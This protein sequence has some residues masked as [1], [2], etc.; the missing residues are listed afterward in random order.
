MDLGDRFVSE[1]RFENAVDRAGQA[2]GN[3]ALINQ[4]N[5]MM[6]GVTSMVVTTRILR[7]V[8]RL[9]AGKKV[10][11]GDLIRL[12]RS[13]ISEEQARKIAAQAEHGERNGDI[14]LANIE[15][16]TDSEAKTAMRDA[17]LT[18]VDNT[19]ITPGAADSPLW[20]RLS[21]SS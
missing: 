9:A 5:T 19:I 16:W 11:K 6:K 4:W 7:T 3:I 17:V 10:S 21:A 12:A 18:D 13:R 8:E 2:F 14:T 15:A 20:T 1:T